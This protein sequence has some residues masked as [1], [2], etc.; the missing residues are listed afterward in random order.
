MKKQTKKD[1]C[2]VK[3]NVLGG[4]KNSS[5]AHVYTTNSSATA[6]IAW[7]GGRHTVQG[8]SRSLI[9]VPTESLYVISY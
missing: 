6:E 9:L 2:R 8:H 4:G 1:K 5:I 3:L 7:L